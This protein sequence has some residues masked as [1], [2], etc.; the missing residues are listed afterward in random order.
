M[1]IVTY[2]CGVRVC[3]HECTYVCVYINS[4]VL[5]FVKQ[6]M[7]KDCF[8]SRI[9][10]SNC[11]TSWLPFCSQAL[12]PH[13]PTPDDCIPGASVT[14]VLPSSPAIFFL[15]STHPCA[16]YRAAQRWRPMRLTAR[17]SS[18]QSIFTKDDQAFPISMFQWSVNVG[19]AILVQAWSSDG[20]KNP[21]SKVGLHNMH[22]FLDSHI[23]ILVQ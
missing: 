20:Y 1:C 14:P 4:C 11:L 2:V 17:R 8:Y 23:I 12:I 7:L 13:T 22:I 19:L 10:Q 5:S 16:N 18:Y 9:S 15:L 6:Q 3:E 21:R